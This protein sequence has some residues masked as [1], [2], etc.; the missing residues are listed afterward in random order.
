M[1]YQYR[2]LIKQNIAPKGAVKIIVSDKNGNRIASMPLG[3][4]TRPEDTKLYS[5]GLLSDIHCG[6]TNEPSKT[7][8]DNA[9]TY[10]EQQGCEFC[11]HAGDMTNVGFHEDTAEHAYNDYQFAEYK[12]VCSAHP[13]LPVYGCCGNHENYGVSIQC[14]LDKLQIYANIQSLYY[15]IEYDEDL[16]IFLSQPNSAK[17]MPD[18]ALIWLEEEFEKN[19]NKR[20]FVFAHPF[21]DE[22]DSGNPNNGYGGQ[23]AFYVWGGTQRNK[24]ISLMKKYNT[25][26]FHGHSHFSPQMQ[27]KFKN[28][29]YSS[30]YGFRSI[31]V[32]SCA[33]YR[34]LENGNKVNYFDN[35]Y[36][37]I[38]DVYKDYIILNGF[39]TLNGELLP[40][41]NYKLNI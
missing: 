5:F 15:S 13:N 32:P 10:F 4:L 33:Y 22:K 11:C 21:I 35:G 39:N 9:L 12:S 34:T 16:F 20:C 18:E 2:G 7:F 37:Y 19:K 1:K 17:P 36:G 27:E 26:F 24:F 31:H 25:V 40:I 8:F 3:H 6:G 38:V 23:S 28:T 29:N 30:Y 14:C 41:A